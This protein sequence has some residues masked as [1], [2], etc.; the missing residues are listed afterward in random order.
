MKCDYGCGKE[1][2]YQFKNLKWCCSEIVNKCEGKRKR[3]SNKKLGKSSGRKGKFG[4]VAWNNGLTKETDERVKRGAENYSNNIKNGITI[5]SFLG[6]HHTEETRKQIGDKLSRNNKGGRCKWYQVQNP[7]GE[8]FNVQGTWERDFCQV[9]NILDESWK[10]IGV[11]DKTH[12]Y[13]WV[14]KDGNEHS[15]TPD[16]YSPK[17]DKYFEIKG[18]LTDD[19]KFKIKYTIDN[20]KLNLELVQKQELKNYLKKIL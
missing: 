2:Q 4:S 15:Y 12:T 13:T 6:K 5:P 1:A 17:L 16:F 9:L 3:D 14:D 10:K 18:Y 20:Y 8:K 11:G 7:L 19:C